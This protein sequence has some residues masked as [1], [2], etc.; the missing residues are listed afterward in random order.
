LCATPGKAKKLGRTVSLRSDWEDVKLDVMR[1]L[2]RQKFENP[3]LR[4]LLMLTGDAILEE[5]NYWH[6]TIWGIY[7]GIGENWLGRILME[8][9]A[10][11][12]SEEPDS[13]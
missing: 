11:I 4:P 1:K 3:F 10:R 12:K 5:H 13:Y 2:I 7:A 6:D 9:R 8:E